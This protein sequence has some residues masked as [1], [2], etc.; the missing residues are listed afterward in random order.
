MKEI[1][2]G[3]KFVAY[4]RGNKFYAIG[5]VITPRRAQD[6]ARPHGHHR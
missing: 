4:L 5:T 6:A 1:K 3:D 2:V